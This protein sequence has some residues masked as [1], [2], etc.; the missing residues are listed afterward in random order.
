METHEYENTVVNAWQNYAV[1]GDR[2]SQAIVDQDIRRFMRETGQTDYNTAMKARRQQVLTLEAT[3]RPERA[4]STVNDRHYAGVE[5]LEVAKKYQQARPDLS[6]KEAFN[7]ALLSNPIL[8]EQYTGCPIRRDGAAEV[9]KFLDQENDTQ[10]REL[11]ATERLSKIVDRIAKL[12]D[13]TRDWT[14]VVRAVFQYPDTIE[15]ASRETMDRLIKAVIN[16]EKIWFHP[17]EYDDV[18]RKLELRLRA[19]HYDLAKTLDSPR[20]IN[21]RALKLML[22]E[23][24]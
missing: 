23:Q 17:S 22:N 13:R 14:E 19:K 24:R 12:P 4:R 7:F 20:N 16:E 9:A 6:D 2:E 11:T 3:M 18:K 10:K 8:G 1:K 21:E 15:K 5:L